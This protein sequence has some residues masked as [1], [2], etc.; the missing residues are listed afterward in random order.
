MCLLLRSKL[1][2]AI[3]EELHTFSVLGV[4]GYWS[5]LLFYVLRLGS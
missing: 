3:E 4:V 1:I 5:P 2:A